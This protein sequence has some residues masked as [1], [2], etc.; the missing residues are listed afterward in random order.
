MMSSQAKTERFLS[1]KLPDRIY[2][3]DKCSFVLSLSPC[4]LRSVCFLTSRVQNI[5]TESYLFI[6][7]I[8]GTI[9]TRKF[10]RGKHKKPPPGNHYFSLS[11]SSDQV[12][13]YWLLMLK[14][15]SLICKVVKKTNH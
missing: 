1:E 12:K 14:K 5:F 8:C 3:Y 11:S 7:I 4:L 6:C 10:V 13:L 9:K 15:N 2:D